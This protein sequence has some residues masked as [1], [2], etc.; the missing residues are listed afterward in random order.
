MTLKIILADSQVAFRQCLRVILEREGFVVAG[1]AGDGAE[2]LRHIENTAPDIVVL[3]MY[4]PLLDA[5]EVSRELRRRGLRTRVV[6]L[7][8]F[9]DDM[10]VLEAFRAGIKAYVLKADVT[11]DLVLAIHKLA[12]GNNYLSPAVTELV[13][14]RYLQRKL[15]SARPLSPRETEILQLMAQDSPVDEIA[16]QLNLTIPVIESLRKTLMEK[17][18]TTNV[19]GLVRH[20]VRQGMIRV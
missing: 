20:A 2:A 18:R 13:V 4:T 15:P 3:D 7:V 10:N 14:K 19:S 11:S 5:V 12:S 9:K 17:I 16:S 1:E 8:V 6:A